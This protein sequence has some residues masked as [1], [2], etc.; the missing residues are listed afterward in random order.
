M[1]V[2]TDGWP[3]QDTA[4]GHR[5]AAILREPTDVP[6]RPGD[7]QEDA[8]A[9]AT[10][11][12]DSL[13][14]YLDEIGVASLLTPSREMLLGAA[15]A[16][17]RAMRDRL[18]KGEVP[19]AERDAATQAVARAEDAQ[20]R[21]IEA[22]L[23]L[24][25]SIA[26]RY[27]Q[28]GLPLPDLIQEGN[29]G[30]LRAVDKFDYRRGYRFSTYATWWIRQAITHALDT[31]SRIV[32]VPVYVAALAR[33]ARRMTEDLEQRT[34][35]E[36]APADIAAALHV[37]SETMARALS[38][39]QPPVSLETGVTADGHAL[40]GVLGDDTAPSPDD[41]AY[42]TL[43]RQHVQEALATLPER[44]RMV[45]QLR[46]G[47]AGHRPHTLAEIGQRLGLTPERARQ[48]EAAALRRLHATDLS[49]EVD[50]HNDA[51]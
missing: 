15:L 50:H 35:H 45:L 32:R 28:H 22:N 46:F 17:G 40:G 6:L 21:L 9:E 43:L 38:S 42:S 19:P 37:P 8:G 2:A 10:R 36:P 18:A 30:L 16:R 23:R 41:A 11:P 24:V 31:Q 13:T 29:L 44:E 4:E 51:A 39:G 25:V 1:A 7:E 27:Q 47:L 33:H 20:R 48:L 14:L 34:G 3:E 5:N 26:R 49:A 12:A